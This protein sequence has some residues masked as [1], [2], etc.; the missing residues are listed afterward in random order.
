RPQA[1]RVHFVQSAH[2]TPSFVSHRRA[3][4][5]GPP[6][7]LS[8]QE[9]RPGAQGLLIT[10]SPGSPRDVGKVLP[11]MEK[12]LTLGRGSGQDVVVREPTVSSSHAKISWAHGRWVLEDEGSLNGT[13]TW[14]DLERQER[15]VLLQ[16]A[17]VQLGELR[18]M[19]VGFE[20]GS[21]AHRRARRYL[22][23][24]DPVT[25]LL[26]GGPFLF[27]LERD[28]RFGAWADLPVHIASYC[29]CRPAGS[30]EDKM[31]ARDMFALW[32]VARR[33]SELTDNILLSLAPSVA[34]RHADRKRPIAEQMTISVSMVGPTAEQ[35][36]DVLD[37]VSAE[38]R[39]QLP[40][41]YRLSTAVEPLPAWL[42]AV[43]S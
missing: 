2:R 30:A 41:G 32:R 20:E 35:A 37:L 34:G 31:N 24:R 7:S 8:R 5:A 15:V 23:R 40:P 27:E 1:R 33:V 10:C 36:R 4:Y 25:G 28:E 26:G 12:S 29:V 42:R 21:N 3:F 6:P 14:H 39:G 13:F 11:L 43:R 19:L 17:E 38:L 22:A 16:G 9:F 18:L